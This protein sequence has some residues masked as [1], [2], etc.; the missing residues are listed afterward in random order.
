MWRSP[1]TLRTSWWWVEEEH[2][3]DLKAALNKVYKLKGQV[4]APDEG[5]SKEG[6]CLERRIQWCDWGIETE[7]NP[8]PGAAQN[9]RD[10]VRQTEDSKDDNWEKT[11]FQRRINCGRSE[12]AQTW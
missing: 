8:H 3:L 2:L 4:L 5:D 6:V 12:V 11:D 9:H 7:G 10:G 1:S